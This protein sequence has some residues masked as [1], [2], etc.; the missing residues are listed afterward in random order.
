MAPVGD[1]KP[2]ERTT[3]GPEALRVTPLHD[4][5][6]AAGAKLVPFAGWEMPIQY[7]GIRE[8]HIAVRTGVGVFDV[9]HMGQVQTRGPEAAECLQR[10]VSNDVRKLPEG[11]AQYSVLCNQSGGVLDDLFT[12]RLGD[13]EFLTVTNAA[14]HERDLAWMRRWGESFDA[15]VV[16]RHGDFAM[17]A[18][19]GPAAR[20]LVAGLSDGQLPGRLHCCERRVAG[21]AVLVCGT[22]YTG[23]E[24]VELLVAPGD[25]VAVWQALLDAG[26]TPVGLGAR[27]TLRLEACFHLYGNDLSEHRDPIGA[28]LG[29]CCA[30][31]TGFIGSEVTSAVRVEK[32]AQRLVPFMINGPGIARQGNRVLP[33]AT[34]PDAPGGEVTSGSFSPCLQRGIGMAYVSRE[35]AKPGT[36]LQ[37]D[38]RGTIREAVVARRPLYRN[39]ADRKGS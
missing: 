37:I 25:A 15:D 12:Y 21:A 11:G 6:R 35:C 10:L 16:D 36:L 4:A 14:N 8:E 24:G 29:W 22:G 33:P 34:D 1:T 13:N 20:A 2:G 23:E 3:P 31:E 5:H 32:P 30:E 27:D 19:Q 28:G 7:S 9:S 38:V 39:D 26:A 17:L 18:V